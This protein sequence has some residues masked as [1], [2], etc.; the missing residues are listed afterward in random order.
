MT[1]EVAAL[2][3]ADNYIQTQCIDLVYSDGNEVFDE[4]VR[5]MHHRESQN[6]LDRTIEFLP[7]VEECAER[8]AAELGL[9]RPEIAVLVSY[10]KMVMYQELMQADLS[11]EPS[12][13]SILLEYFPEALR[14]IYSSEIRSH[15]LKSEIIN[16]IVTNEFVNRLGPT[17]VFRM[18]QELNVSVGDIAAA[19]LIARS[20]FRMSELWASI[21]SLDNIVSS[22][23][24][25]RMQILVRGLIERATHWLLRSRQ[26]STGIEELV[27]RFQSGIDELIASMPECLADVQRKT[28]E[29]RINHFKQAGAPDDI[30]LSVARVVPLSSSLDIVEIAMSL[31]QP[32][33]EIASVYFAIGQHLELTWLRDQI[34]GLK[35]SSH[36][37]TLATAELRSDLHYQQRHLC[38]E[39]ASS[40][41][42]DLPGVERVALWAGRYPQ[43]MG[44]FSTLVTEL[45]ANTSLDFAML[46]LAV[47]EVH[48][49]LRSDRP[50]A[51]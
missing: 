38:A 23:E 18:Q 8:M 42:Q 24:Q 2:V 33:K 11:D 19:F 15:R 36:W 16:T 3:L 1:E 43:A 25:Y 46:S 20:T 7:E 27:L 40:T 34:G 22:D 39:I 31:E 29:Q 50:L 10:S 32:V 41:E 48:K 26:P 30:A 51:S 44:K 12:A 6:L 47:N 37:H 49:L 35:V 28:L 13:E 9:L 21:E 14:K 4:Q 5:F 45:K 17:F